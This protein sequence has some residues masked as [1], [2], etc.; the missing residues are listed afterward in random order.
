MTSIANSFDFITYKEYCAKENM[1]IDETLFTSVKSGLR[2]SVFRIYGWD[3]PS[4]TIGYFQKSENINMSKCFENQIPIIRRMTGGRAVYH[5]H[6][7]TCSFFFKLDKFNYS[8]KLIFSA[9]S[10]IILNGLSS[11]GLSGSISHKTMGEAKNP[12]CFQTTSVCEIV[13]KNGIKLVGSAMLI[14]DNVVMMQSSI[15]LSN[16][17]ENLIYFLNDF[18]N[19]DHKNYLNLNQ[20]PDEKII[21]QFIYGI[22][23][24]VIL[25]PLE[26]TYT[27]KKLSDNLNKTK[28]SMDWWNFGR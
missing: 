14:K 2:N 21:D 15:P 3:K 9:I 24:G 20:K 16:T 1:A 19:K 5:H 13:N 8:K 6:E 12:N 11:I 7:I 22:G 27:E 4:I 18:A 23:K 17:N 10:N 26:L 28:Y 25:N